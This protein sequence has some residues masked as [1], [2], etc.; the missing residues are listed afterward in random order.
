VRQIF[1][2]NNAEKTVSFRL[3]GERSE[4]FSRFVEAIRKSEG[5]EQDTIRIVDIGGTFAWWRNFSERLTQYNR[6][7]EILLVNPA[8]D[9]ENQ[10]L[11]YQGISIS[12][13][14]GDARNLSA[15]QD[16]EF[17]VAFSNSVLEHV[18]VF[19]EQERMV[20]EIKRVA[21]YHFV[22]TPY[23]FFPIEPHFLFPFWHFLPVDLR[24]FLHQKFPIGWRGKA[25]SH[26]MARRNIDEIKL[27]DKRDMQALF[28]ESL[29]LK[30]QV[31]GMTKSLVA[32]GGK[33][34]RV[35]MAITDGIE[36]NCR[37]RVLTRKGVF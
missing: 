10:S 15:F 35:K 32:I 1:A 21:K 24:V 36:K 11:N 26:A 25:E 8:I 22:Q 14:I 3:R 13:R 4:L 30:E 33:E 16:Q 19:S 18:G 9:L 37:Y 34:D 28:P 5:L 31:F 12:A 20:C 29:L 7:I 23:R 27:L 17:H 6:R 2:D